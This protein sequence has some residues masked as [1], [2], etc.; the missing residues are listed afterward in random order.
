MHA[1][2]IRYRFKAILRRAGL[3]TNR[4]VYDLRHT[5]ATL[6]AA[7]GVH[8]KVISERLGHADPAFTMRTYTAF[9]GSMQGQAADAFERRFG[10]RQAERPQPPLQGRMQPSISSP[11]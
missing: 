4:R 5:C 10:T 7:A 2:Q 11:S 6:L 9:L 1:T 3:P 8:P